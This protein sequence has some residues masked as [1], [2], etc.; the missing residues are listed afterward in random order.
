[1]CVDS[2]VIVLAATPLVLSQ[3]HTHQ[4]SN[5][6]TVVV[7]DSMP[8][9]SGHQRGS[10]GRLCLNDAKKKKQYFLPLPRR[11]S[12]LHFTPS[13]VVPSFERGSPICRPRKPHT[14]VLEV[15]SCA[16]YCRSH[17]S[18]EAA[19][20]TLGRTPSM[21]I[22]KH[23]L[24]RYVISAGTPTNSTNLG[25]IHSIPFSYIPCHHKTTDLIRIARCSFLYHR[26]T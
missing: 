11:H 14:R 3:P 1:M 15:D 21:Y 9:L 12:V 2:L 26:S 19:T 5:G 23:Y 24:Y 8:P 25:T 16:E 17:Q 6:G 22:K 4:I 10:A 13:P 7:Y 18:S 20:C